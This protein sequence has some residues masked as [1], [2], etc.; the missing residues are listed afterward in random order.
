M[1]NFRHQNRQL[2]K[3]QIDIGMLKRRHVNLISDFFQTQQHNC[4]H[5]IFFPTYIF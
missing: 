4:S 3:P 5:F 2:L 1:D